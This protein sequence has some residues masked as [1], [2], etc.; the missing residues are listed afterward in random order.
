MTILGEI[1]KW[2]DTLPLWQ[3]HAIATLYERP[4][5]TA[6][7]LDDILALLKV[8]C[9]IPDPLDRRSRK[10][11]AEQI[12]APPADTRLVQLASIKDMRH[13]NA[14]AGG[15]TLPLSPTGLTLIYGENGAGKSGYSRVLKQACRARDQS[16]RIRPNAHLP[17]AATGKASARFDV[18]VDGEPIELTWTDGSPAPA[19]MSAIAIFDSR[20]ARAYVDN[21]GD[22]AYSPYGLDILAGLAKAC[23]WLK[24]KTGREQAAARPNV[25][26][27]AK[28]AL[29]KTEAG[30]LAAGLSAS[31]RKEDVERI[32]SLSDAEFAQLA[33]LT[34]TLGEADPK[35]KAADLRLKAQR[36]ARLE[37]RVG[38][39]LAIVDSAKIAR[40]KDLVA[41]SNEAKK[42]A[43][44]AA[45]K[46]EMPA[47]LNG[48]GGD[49]WMEMFRI[50]REFCALCHPK[51][52]FPRLSAESRCP[53]CQTQ[54]GAPGS[55][56]L[57]AFDEFIEGAAT[58]AAKK[59][60]DAAIEAFVAI[61][62][63]DLDLSIDATLI[64]DLESLP[65]LLEACRKLQ[66]RLRERRA[67]VRSAATPGGSW[68]D[69]P[70]L[71]ADPREALAAVQKGLL[72]EAKK[73]DESLDAKAR[74]AMERELAE[75]SARRQLMDLKV[76]AL[77]AITR[78]QLAAKL[79]DCIAA[80]ATQSIS[81]K[82]TELTKTMATQEVAAALTEELHSL[83]VHDL[84]VVMR[85][86]SAK[87]KTSFK[88]VLETLGGGSPQ[89]ILSEG[90]QRAIAI[91][92]FLSEVRLDKGLGGVVFD[93]P[94]SSLDHVRRERVARRLAQESQKRQV[95][96]LTHDVFFLSVLMLEARALGM[97]P[98]ALNLQR[99]PQ[100][101]GVAEESLPF[102]GASTK[103]RVGI[104]RNKQVT[105]ARMRREGDEAGYRLHARDFYNDLRMTWE[106]GVEEILL[107]SVVLRFRKGIETNR[108]KK[109]TIEAQD[110]EA[111]TAGVGKCSNYTGHDGAMEANLPTPSP[112]DMEQDISALEAWRKSAVERMHKR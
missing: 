68:D 14:L 94:V 46:F 107:N 42:V 11:S 49:V 76:A 9:G 77:D 69:I 24:D 97:E 47:F 90:E 40:V 86:E 106:R 55:A 8:S 5:L 3:Q 64:N 70:E 54:L 111:I 12:A 21:Q 33:A 34:Q 109:I 73:L 35:R 65:A 20:C 84:R 80:T 83:G 99:T 56:R 23:A 44:A 15:K 22:F 91:S 75:L 41:T 63:A 53:L 87:A 48:T 36:A 60:Y 78:F 61:D 16:E 101:F 92:S 52:A 71:G 2:S 29:S 27:F 31:T 98:K 43:K 88:L 25:D 103:D 38:E 81:R 93:D 108:L 59:A 85:P 58:K 102:A 74:I 39:S 82:S 100:G 95:V 72:D 7:D 66:A 4:E 18:L 32:G 110:L 89:D 79:R 105:C 104:L 45:K 10:L 6:D 57:A 19:E 30:A 17:P 62:K 50:A 26:L 37:Q 13:V 51:E 1:Q 28:L 96:V 112:E 67:A